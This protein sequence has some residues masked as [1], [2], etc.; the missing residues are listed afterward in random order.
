MS[1]YGWTLWASIQSGTSH[2]D[3]DFWSWAWRNTNARSQSSAV[4]IWQH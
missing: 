4:P 1:K 2:V 3:F